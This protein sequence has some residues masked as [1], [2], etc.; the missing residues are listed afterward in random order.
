MLRSRL[1]SPIRPNPVPSPNSA[2]TTGRPIASSE[3]KLISNTTTAAPI[4]ISVV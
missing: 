4:P 3:P 2:V 1:L